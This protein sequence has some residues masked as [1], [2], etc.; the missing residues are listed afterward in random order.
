MSGSAGWAGTAGHSGGGADQG[1]GGD[2]GVAGESGSGGDD[3]S[4]ELDLTGVFVKEALAGR[5]EENG[6]FFVLLDKPLALAVDNG[7]PQR[8]LVYVLG[9]GGA[10]RL[11]E[12]SPTR[13]LLDFAL[14]PSGQVTVLFAA[15]EG[16]TLERLDA[17]GRVLAVHTITDP[18][19][20]EDP[21]LAAGKPGGPIE[22]LSYDTGAVAAAGE[23]VVVATRTGRHS[24]VAYR[25]ALDDEGFAQTWRSLVVPPHGLYGIGLTGGSYDTFGQLGCHTAVHVAHDEQGRSYVAVQHPH[26]GD[27]ALLEAH[28]KVFGESLEGDPDGLDLYVTRIDDQGRRLGTSVVG[29]DEQDE[30]YGLRATRDAAIVTGRTEHWN[31]QGT[32]FDALFARID[33]ESGGVEVH[34]LDV[35]GGDLAFDAL[36]LSNGSWLV[37]GVSDYSQNPHGASVSEAS[38]AFATLVSK[39]GDAVPLSAPDGER[40]NEARA[41]LQLNDGRWLVVGMLDGPGTHSADGDL[42][43]LRASGFVAPLELPSAPD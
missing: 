41:L 10:R 15:A 7:S 36:P 9:E 6:A 20:D 12:S 11:T 17:D 31:D 34:E 35:S 25:L 32:G 16:Y 24:V 26:T 33:G 8:Q 27:D 19:I 3:G 14:H 13:F 2:I 18:Q 39:A 22:R 43:L 28:R 30:L 42:S 37:A 1:V 21:P 29:T 4:H 40:H 38:R 5:A 23:D